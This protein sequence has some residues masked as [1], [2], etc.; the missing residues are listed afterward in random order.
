MKSYK[1]NF[2]EKTVL[3]RKINIEDSGDVI[4]ACIRLACRDMMTVGRFY[5]LG[6]MGEKCEKFGEILSK[7]GYRFSIEL[8]EKTAKIFSENS[9]IEKDNKYVTT[10][11]LA[12][13][14]VNMTYK[15]FYVYYEYIDEEIDFTECDCPLDSI[16]LKSLNKNDTPWSKITKVKY[17]E[18]QEKIPTSVPEKFKNEYAYASKRIGKLAYDF[19]VW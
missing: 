5:A 7:S 10:F 8:I 11:G 6:D 14:L 2:L 17:I 15:Y 13:K 3:G 16:I 4:N 9:K 12:Q 19:L 18:I 1:I